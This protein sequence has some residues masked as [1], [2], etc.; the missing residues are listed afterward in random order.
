VSAAVGFIGLGQI[1]APMAEH[2]LGWPG[3]L[4]VCDVRPDACEP[5]VAKGATAV[6]TPADVA[7]AADV[8]SVMVRDDAQVE[9]VLDGVLAAGRAGVVVA[10]HSTIAAGTAERLAERAAPAGVAV[11]DAPVSGGFMGAAEGT[12]AVMVG[13]DGDAVERCVEPFGRWAGLVAHLGPV[14]AGTRAKLARNIVTFVSYAAVGEA[15]RLAEE[16]GVDLVR[17]GEVVRHSDAITGGAGAV[18]IRGTAGVLAED[19]PLRGIFA[20]TR[21]LG[22]KDLHLALALGEEL[23]VDL[24][25]ARMALELLG[26]S[27]GV[28]S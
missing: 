14:G 7:T 23:D 20:H 13:G 9:E 6:A 4:V 17:L 11:V 26:P 25:L 28:P 27:L 19:D 5:F 2:L 3:G 22:E 16:A 15:L 1:G 24:P 12:L 21:Q 8:I 10:V 18:A